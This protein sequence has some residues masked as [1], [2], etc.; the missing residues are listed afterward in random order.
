MSSETMAGGVTVGAAGAATSGAV[1]RTAVAEA[2]ERAIASRLGWTSLLFALAYTFFILG[3]PL[4]GKDA[5][6]LRTDMRW[7]DVIDL[8]TPLV[9]LPAYWFLVRQRGSAPPLEGIALVAFLLLGA[10]WV[11]GQGMHLSANSVSNLPGYDTATP[12]GALTNFYDEVLSH[13]VWHVAAVGLI[14]LALYRQWRYPLAAGSS[15]LWLPVAAGLIYGFTF[16]T[17]ILEGAT[18]PFGLPATAVIA[19]LA[20]LAGRGNLRAQPV[21]TFVLV[22]SVVALVLWTG[23]FVANGSFAE[24]C[25]VTNFC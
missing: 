15:G 22:A 7:Q 14:A 12:L 4:L 17:T 9:L 24:P 6:P 10:F 8:A 20:V 13:Y 1:A 18:V 11:E 21:T 2:T 3:P 23:W 5:F 25:S 16:A 19:A